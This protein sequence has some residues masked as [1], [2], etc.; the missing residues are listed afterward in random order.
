MRIRKMYG[1]TINMGIS[2]SDKVATISDKLLAS[3]R[4]RETAVRPYENE[5]EL[6]EY[7]ALFKTDTGNNI[8][9]K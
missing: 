6:F 7:Q 9:L 2:D 1:N 4:I 8:N 3:S 5:R